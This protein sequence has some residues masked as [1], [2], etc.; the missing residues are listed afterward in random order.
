MSLNKKLQE[1]MKGV[2]QMGWRKMERR[3]REES[4]KEGWGFGKKE[5]HMRWGLRRM[6]VDVE[7]EEAGEEKVWDKVKSESK[8]GG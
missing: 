8:S 4:L 7:R 1:K 5:E 3:K 6:R 2:R